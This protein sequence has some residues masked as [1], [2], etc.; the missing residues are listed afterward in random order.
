MAGTLVDLRSSPPA[1]LVGTKAARL[2]WLLGQGWPVPPGVVVPASHL[3][4]PGTTDL[5]G[6]GTV[7]EELGAVLVPQ[8][9]YVVRSSADAEDSGTCSFAGQFATVLDVSGTD[10]VLAAV[11]EVTASTRTAQVAAYARRV[12]VD[13]STI[14]MSVIVQEMVTAVASGVAFSRD[15]V[16]GG[17]RVVVEA[18]AGRGETLVGRGATPQR[19]TCAPGA[20]PVRDADPSVPVPPLL[21]DAVLREVV[22]LTRAVAAADGEPTDVE[23]AWDGTRLWLVQSRPITSLTSTARVWSSRIARD[24]LPGLIPPL[25]WSVNV[26]VVNRVWVDVLDRALGPTGLEPESLAHPFGYRAYFDMG[27]FGAVFTSLGMPAD[28]LEQMRAGTGRSSMRPSVGAILRRSPRLLGLVLELRRWP[29]E[30]HAQVR[31]AEASR[32]E[33]SGVDLSSLSDEDLLDR[34]DRLRLGFAD[35]ARF[36]V[37]TPL[38]ADMAAARVRRAAHRRG[39]DPTTVDPGQ[40][41]ERV[42][43]LSPVHALAAVDRDDD[44]AWADY[45]ERFGHLSDSPNDCSR[46][47]WAEQGERVRRNLLGTTGPAGAGPDAARRGN[48]G[49]RVELLERTPPWLRWRTARAWSRA[50][51]LRLAREDVGYAYARFYGLFRPVFL[52]AGARLTSRGLLDGPDDVFLLDLAELRAAL[53]GAL[54]DTR[55]LAARR[56]EE[57]A[58]AAELDWPETIVGDDPVPVLGRAG[59]RVLHGTPTSRGRH[60]GPARIVTSLA[61]APEIGPQDVLVLEA[62]DVTWT[63]LLLRAGAV[64]TETGGMLSHASIVARELG[65]PCVA[66]VAGVLRV[67]DGTRLC[68]DG[69]AGEVLVLDGPRAPDGT[70]P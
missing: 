58:E 2:G 45:L 69:G 54:P 47:T 57:M 34:V 6:L 42:R 64:V 49:G 27:A 35:L 53:K 7:R 33:E 29:D 12:G 15:P 63:P 3:G 18:V 70:L 14:R 56:R 22:A 17:P 67:T 25:V 48:V 41:L 4:S 9:R 10:E 20:D 52:E 8:R 62:A 30:A 37:V 36:N 68:V 65:L 13:A 55:S 60:T 43:E 50:A 39:L 19:W 44:A 26:P 31:L 51:T 66:S 59:A 24:V 40:E 46:A 61:N 23:W 5:R 16:T 1:G 38:L 11:L 32:A 28:A 21:P